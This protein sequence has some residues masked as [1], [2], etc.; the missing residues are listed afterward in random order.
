MHHHLS[1]V[2]SRSSHSPGLGAQHAL[3]ILGCLWKLSGSH[4]RRPRSPTAA[5]DLQTTITSPIGKGFELSIRRAFSLG[6][7]K[8]L[9]CKTT[10]NSA[11]F[12]ARKDRCFHTALPYSNLN[13]MTICRVKGRVF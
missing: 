1:G 7:S 9:G 13:W 2:L 4:I 11:I 5:H 8:R 3:L 12:S 10:R 6:M